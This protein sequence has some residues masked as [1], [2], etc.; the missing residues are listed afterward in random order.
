MGNG[1]VLSDLKE[2]VKNEQL[3]EYVKFY[4]IQSGEALD[5]IF[6]HCD[7]GLTVLAGHRE[8][9]SKMSD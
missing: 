4:G 3:T 8:G 6:C 5:Q 1:D 7:I 2:M 9:L